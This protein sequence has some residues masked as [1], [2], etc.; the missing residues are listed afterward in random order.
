MTNIS[1]GSKVYPTQDAG[2]AWNPLDGVAFSM[3]AKKVKHISPKFSWFC[4]GENH[5]PLCSPSSLLLPRGFGEGMGSQ[6][7]ESLHQA[8][9][10]PCGF[11]R[12]SL[13]DF[14]V[15]EESPDI[16][17]DGETDKKKHWKKQWISWRFIFWVF[18]KKIRMD[19]LLTYLLL[20]GLCNGQTM[21]IMLC[22]YT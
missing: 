14:H 12:V 6:L 11:W 22:M 15:V 2:V 4:H 10:K 17:I 9:G 3:L 7:K 5:H 19:D 21:D 16:T 13:Y 20:Q 1:L 18:F 8:L